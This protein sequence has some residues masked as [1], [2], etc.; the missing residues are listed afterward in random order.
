MTVEPIRLGVAD[1]GELLT[2]QRAAYATEAQAH[3]DPRLPPLV[4]TLAEL[5]AELA[6]DDVLAYGFRDAGRLVGAVRLTVHPDEPVVTLGRLMVAPDRQGEGLGT[7]L[8]AAAERLVLPGTQ[9]IRLFTGEYSHGNLRLY[10]RHG[11]ADTH[12]VSVGA[13]D[14]LHLAKALAPG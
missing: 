10:R 3:D 5:R 14:L 13:Y 1:V 9:A 8:L 6:R 4:Q 12:R 2:L 7:A 11:Y